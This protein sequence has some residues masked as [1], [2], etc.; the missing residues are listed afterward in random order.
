MTYTPPLT[1]TAS[2]ETLSPGFYLLGCATTE[3]VLRLEMTNLRG[4]GIVLPFEEKTKVLISG[5]LAADL[6]LFP[7]K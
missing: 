4:R 3:G 6:C 7:H 1:C 5:C 2:Q